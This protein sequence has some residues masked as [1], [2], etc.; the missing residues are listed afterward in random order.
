VVMI[1]KAYI[2]LFQ[3]IIR[4]GSESEADGS[5]TTPSQHG[6]EH[7]PKVSRIQFAKLI[8]LCS[9]PIPKRNSDSITVNPLKRRKNEFDKVEDA[10]QRSTGNKENAQIGGKDVEDEEDEE[11]DENKKKRKKRKKGRRGSKENELKPDAIGTFPTPSI[12]GGHPDL[13]D[14]EPHWAL[15]PWMSTNDIIET[16][17]STR[18]DSHRDI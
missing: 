16:L 3:P 10:K 15:G 11:D 5:L 4:D 13:L 17:V 1:L 7:I 2:G 12:S 8:Q 6:S 14:L 18:A 9:R